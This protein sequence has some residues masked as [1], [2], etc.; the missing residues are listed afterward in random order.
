MCAFQSMKS[1]DNRRHD[2]HNDLVRTIGDFSLTL[3]YTNV[4]PP[5]K[6]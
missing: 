4:P 5:L 6:K 3:S 2:S 1:V